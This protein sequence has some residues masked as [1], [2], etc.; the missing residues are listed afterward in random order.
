MII[1]L[2]KYFRFLALFLAGHVSKFHEQSLYSDETQPRRIGSERTRYVNMGS[3][4]FSVP[5][6]PH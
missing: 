4:V 6:L 1:S 3:S 2:I 5:L